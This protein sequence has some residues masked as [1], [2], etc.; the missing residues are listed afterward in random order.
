M[1]EIYISIVLIVVFICAI[2]IGL[3]ITNQG[4]E[5]KDRYN[6]LINFPYE[7]ESKSPRLNLVFRLVLALFCGVCS[8]SSIVILFVDGAYLLEK[9][10]SLLLIFNSFL[11]VGL[12]LLNMKNYKI[13]LINSVSFMV[14]N[15]IGYF[16]IGYLPIRDNF[17]FY[18][19]W[20]CIVGFIIFAMLIFF[21]ILP[22]V[23][24]WYVLKKDEEGNFTRGKI[25]PLAVLEWVNILAYILIFVILAIN[26][27]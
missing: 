11:L 1:K 6:F 3:L 9:V 16:L 2:I 8:I 12:F 15:S 20:I 21:L 13:H 5:K 22:S 14:I 27:F 17:T 23:K 7:M 24:N 26:Y 18:P 19:L 4:K 25:F 10:L